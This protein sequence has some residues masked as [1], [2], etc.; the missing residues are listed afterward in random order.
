MHGRTPTGDAHDAVIYQRTKTHF[1]L[2]WDASHISTTRQ[3]PVAAK[4]KCE[5]KLLF[6]PFLMSPTGRFH[7]TG[8]VISHA[9][10]DVV[11]LVLVHEICSRG[12][13]ATTISISVKLD[14]FPGM[15]SVNFKSECILPCLNPCGTKPCLLAFPGSKLRIVA[16]HLTNLPKMKYA[17]SRCTDVS[18]H[19]QVL[20]LN[21]EHAGIG[22]FFSGEFWKSVLL[23]VT[24]QFDSPQRWQSLLSSVGTHESIRGGDHH[25]G[26]YIGFHVRPRHHLLIE[27]ILLNTEALGS[28]SGVTAAN[29]NISASIRRAW[30]ESWALCHGT[31]SNQ[32]WSTDLHGSDAPPPR[33]TLETQNELRSAS[34]ANYQGE[35]LDSNSTPGK[36]YWALVYHSLKPE[37][38]LA[39]TPWTQIISEKKDMELL[40]TKGR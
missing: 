1:V 7:R 33:L 2:I 9:A 30:H 8:C 39:R 13:C 22:C 28:T 32:Q 37:N 5:S 36:R 26:L 29:A 20:R 3:I 14:S 40:E 11:C 27:D 34:R 16:C 21:Y 18:V 15:R 4:C 12:L 6:T 10:E 19:K 31:S 25:E 24:Q 23:F 17:W 35:L 38:R